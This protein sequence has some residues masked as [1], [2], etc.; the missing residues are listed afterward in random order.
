MAPGL[1]LTGLWF[2]IFLASQLVIFHRYR[3]RRPSKLIIRLIAITAIGHMASIALLAIEP[4]TLP[5]SLAF[6]P[7]LSLLGGGLLLACLLVLY[8]PFFYVLTTSLSVATLI[9]MANTPHRSIQL[10]DLTSQFASPEFVTARL[11]ILC[12]NGY[13]T[14]TENN[15]YRL[16]ARAR[17]FVRLFDYIKRGWGLGTGG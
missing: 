12:L 2:L 7:A 1:I 8:M 11:S 6:N 16:T 14:C 17:R 9:N 4:Q 15:G 3:I 5:Q 13:L 10:K